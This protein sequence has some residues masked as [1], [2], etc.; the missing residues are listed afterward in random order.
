MKVFFLNPPFIGKF[1]RTSRSPAITRGGSIYYPFWLAYA[2]GVSDREGFEVQLLDAPAE[3]YSLEEVKRKILQFNPQLIVIDTSTPSIY[4]D[5][6][7]AEELKNVLP[8]AFVVL[9]GTHVSALAEE[10]LKLSGKLDAIAKGEY[11]FTIKNLAY[12]LKNND[13]L[14]KV[15]GLVFRQDNKIILNQ[16]RALIENV[17][18]LPFASQVYKKYL[19]IKKYFFLISDYPMVM[20]ITG[21]GCPFRCFFCVYPQTFHSRKY[22]FR[23][24]KNVV[25][26]FE[27]IAKELP[28]VKGIGIEDDTFTANPQR[29]KEICQLLI[30]RGVKIRW[31]CNVRP[32]L[33]LETMKWMKK[34]GCQ[35]VTVGFES[36]TQQILDNIHKG[37][38]VEQI[39]EFVNNAKKAGILVHGCFIAGNP[40]ETK[41]TLEKMLK[42]AKTL[43]C[44]TMQFYP[45]L[46][47]PGT[48]AY[49]WAQK[50]NYLSTSDFSRWATKMGGYNCL[51]NLPGLSS[52]EIADFCDKATKEY[53]LRLP[54]ILMKI[55][56]IIFH[57]R[58]IGRTFRAA[59]TFFKHTFLTKEY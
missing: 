22:R 26:E 33:D 38:K 42:F 9:V 23:S 18:E 30:K 41:Q 34:A 16:P 1:S 21:R 31:Y 53:Y 3:G 50:N 24:P 6:K 54:Y 46:V 37:I 49:F 55:K 19:D 36:A 28:E 52:K 12:C 44:D 39:K 32:D 47:Y 17:D 20:M 48:E 40:G 56:Q 15:D 2:A 14:K 57:P 45:L 13:D 11:D 7:T 29:T 4:S 59:I 5:I 51:L 25:D 10:T 43:N 8:N 58:E 35:L 27:Y